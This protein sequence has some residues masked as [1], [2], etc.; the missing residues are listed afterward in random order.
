M[1]PLRILDTLIFLP[2]AVSVG[3]ATLFTLAARLKG[4]SKSKPGN[5]D[6]Q[7]FFSV[8]IPSY[9]EDR[10]ILGTV[11]QFLLQTY[12]GYHLIVVADH[13]QPTT[14][15][16]LRGMPVTV[17]EATYEQSSKA[18]ALRLASRHILPESQY[19]V[20]L[21]ADNIVQPTFLSQLSPF[22]TKERRQALQCHRTAKNIDTPTAMLDAASEEINNTIFRLGHNS[23]GLSSALI[24]SGMC[25]PTEWFLGHVHR[26]HTSGE[27][28]EFE[29]MLLSEDYHIRYLPHIPV[30]DEK[31]QTSEGFGRQRQRWM[32]A[33]LATLLHM[34]RHPHLSID[35][36]DKTLQQ[37]L[38]PRS[39]CILLATLMSC[40]L[41]AHWVILLIILLLTLLMATP[42]FL[43][44][45][46]LL[47]SVKALPRLIL[48]MFLGLFRL[49]GQ[50]KKFQHTEHGANGR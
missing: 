21:D 49:K 39:L 3:Y 47:S 26:L 19:T 29:A 10:V 34:L 2:T 42:R 27:D 18:K 46:T 1:T 33:Q 17:V 24:G 16:A 50:N 44:G 41:Q 36:L 15:Q 13:M 45:T 38:I 11:S 31:V 20:I 12:H 35:Y 23:L 8:I 30:F 37:A 7:P 32:A 22:C 40:T 5:E 14:L 6:S 9:A 28:K 4:W 25:F 43:M 48:Q